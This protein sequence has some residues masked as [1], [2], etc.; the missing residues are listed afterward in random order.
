MRIRSMSVM[1][2][3]V[4]FLVFT[5]DCRPVF[6]EYIVAWGRNTYGQCDVPEGNDFVAIAAGDAH[7]LALRSDGSLVSWGYGECDAPK[8]TDFVAIAAYGPYS[9]ALKSDG[10]LVVWSY[11]E[12]DRCDAPKGN[13]FV[14]VAAGK[15]H[16]VALKSDGSLLTWGYK[17]NSGLGDVL[18]GNDFVAI[19]AGDRHSLALRSDGSIVGWGRNRD[20]QCDAPTGNDFTAI[21]AG[22]NNSYALKS[23]GSLVTWGYRKKKGRARLPQGNDFIAI[24]NYEYYNMAL[25]SNGSVVVWRSKQGVVEGNNF[26]AITAGLNHDLALAIKPEIYSNRQRPFPH[27]PSK[28]GTPVAKDLRVTTTE[29]TEV[30]ITLVGEGFEGDGF[31]YYISDRPDYGKLSNNNGQANVTYTPYVN[32]YGL[33]SFTYSVHQAKLRSG[34]ATVNIAV[35]PVL[36]EPVAQDI[37]AITC[38]DRPIEIDLVGL[39]SDGDDLKYDIR[40]RPKNGKLK[41]I[42]VTHNIYRYTPEADFN[43]KDSFTFEASDGQS[44]SN[45]ATVNITVVALSESGLP[46]A[47]ESV[48]AKRVLEP[49]KVETPVDVVVDRDDNL[50][51]LSAPAE[52]NSQVL[53]CNLDLQIEHTFIVDANSPRGIAVSKKHV[54]VA[55]TGGNR[56]LRYSKDG[57]IDLSFGKDG[58]VGQRG[59][60]EGEFNK[61]WGIYVDGE[62]NIYIS[63]S[64]NNRVQIFDVSGKF[65]SQW[66]QKTDYDKKSTRRNIVIRDKRAERMYVEML[67]SPRHINGFDQVRVNDRVPI[68]KPTGFYFQPSGLSG[69]IF[70]AD[71]KNHKIKQ[72]SSGSGYL[73]SACG[74]KGNALGSFNYPMD[75]DY[76]LEMDQ[77]VVADSGNNRIQVLQLRSYGEMFSTSAMTCIQEISD[78]NLSG[79]MGV[80]VVTKQP[81]QFIYVADTGNNRVVKLQNGFY[82]AGASPVDVWEQF[83][84]ALLAD[85]IDAALSFIGSWR[86]KNYAKIF[87]QIRPHLK[88]YVEGMGDLIPSSQDAG[89]AVYELPTTDPN[90]NTLLFPVH[91]IMGEDGTWK[92]ENF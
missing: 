34:Y 35:T 19:A 13:D 20:G 26:T 33:D 25:R 58:S 3:I 30:H 74:E 71:T 10:S 23:D 12:S 21:A 27:K 51:I 50:Y 6:A 14:A 63:D 72:L 65:K 53:V 17:S 64:G 90:G 83:K 18:D 81:N 79:P 37:E 32:Y 89:S 66:Q 69:K 86:R 40:S 5:W 78:Q 36:D 76:D 15:T 91:F 62:E 84:A 45:L 49:L 55:N 46:T 22:K 2:M 67:S 54:Y 88:E 60:G 75:V 24:S 48:Y 1:K 73:Y 56:V 57:R 29:D 43:G 4:L 39:D 85:D 42:D 28:P 38:K 8:G 61:P 47:R 41:L 82:R 16:A 11:Y 7:S 70:L 87:K 9:I 59:S 52:G 80:A 44:M 92:I 77:L 68:R 31:K